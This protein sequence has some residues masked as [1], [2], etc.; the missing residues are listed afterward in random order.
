MWSDP[1]RDPGPIA[2]RSNLGGQAMR[3]RTASVATRNIGPASLSRPGE[4][5][6]ERVVLH[7]VAHDLGER[8]RQSLVVIVRA[9]TAAPANGLG[10]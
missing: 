5:F 4:S 7:Q 9:V 8:I 3:A 10:K 6:A 1:A 2:T